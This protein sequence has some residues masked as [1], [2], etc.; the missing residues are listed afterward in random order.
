MMCTIPC[1][2]PTGSMVQVFISRVNLHPSCGLVELLVSE[3]GKT[4]CDRT[5]RERLTPLRKFDESEGKAGDFCLVLISGCWHRACVVSIQCQSCT[6]ILVD[7]GQPH[8]AARE[9]LAWGRDEDFNGASRGHVCILANVLSVGIECP[10]S[11]T[12]FLSSLPGKTFK[13]LVQHV[14]IPDTM[15]LIDIPLISKSMCKFGVA[16]KM[17]A[18]EFKCLVLKCW[19][20][21][22]GGVNGDR[23][24]ELVQKES[25]L[26]RDEDL[27]SPDLMYGIFET[28]KVTEVIDPQHIFCKLAIFSKAVKTFSEKIHRHYEE[29]ADVTELKPRHCG[30]P[31]AS[32]GEDGRWQRATLKQN[33]E[34][35]SCSAKVFFVDEGRTE[36][37]KI[38]N[39]RPLHET[40]LKMPVFTYR[41]S[42]DGVA[43]LGTGW[44]PDQTGYLKSLILNRTFVARLERH[45][46]TKDVYS[47]N[48]YGENAVCINHAYSE[49][50][51]LQQKGAP[52]PFSD[53]MSLQE[54][55]SLQQPTNVSES[56]GGAVLNQ[57]IQNEKSLSVTG[58]STTNAGSIGR[59]AKF[60]GCDGLPHN[61]GHL[62]TGYR[63]EF[64]Y[65]ND[66]LNE[67][68]EVDV[69]ISCVESSD[70]FWCQMSK[71][72][73]SLKRLMAELQDFYASPHP[74]P[75]VESVCV[76]RNPDNGKW[77]R[78]KIMTNNHNPAVEVRFID[79]GKTQRVPVQDIRPLD[80]AFLR[81]N[82]QAF[83]C[84]LAPKNDAS[85]V[86][87]SHFQKFV[88]TAVATKE[89]LKCIVK[90]KRCDEEGLSVN[91]VDITTLFGSASKL[92]DQE[93]SQAAA[94]VTSDKYTISEHGV[95]VG[96]SEKVLVTCVETV[97]HFYCQL[98]RNSK[99]L[100]RVRQT[101]KKLIRQPQESGGQP[102]ANSVCLARYTDNVWYRGQ[103]VE[104][105]PK[106]KVHLV[107][108]GD[109]L[110]VK[111]SDLRLLHAGACTSVPVLAV[112]L[113]LFGV[114][115]NTPPEVNHW[116]ANQAIGRNFDIS[117]VE[118]DRS[119]TLMV[120][121]F[122]ESLNI[123]E[124]IREAIAKVK[125]GTTPADK[126]VL[127]MMEEHQP[128]QAAQRDT[129][130]PGVVGVR[131]P[132]CMSAPEDPKILSPN[133]SIEVTAEGSLDHVLKN[134]GPVTANLISRD[135]ET[136]AIARTQNTY[137]NPDIQ[138]NQME[139]L[140]ASFVVGPNYFWCQI[141]SEEDLATLVQD[142][143]T[144][145][146][147]LLNPET[148]HLGSPCLALSNKTWYRAQVISQAEDKVHVIL[149]DYGHESDVPMQNLKVLPPSLLELPP[150]AFLCALKEF[151]ES[152]G[153]WNED[154]A[155]FFCSL[156]VDKPLKVSVCSIKEHLQKAVP[157]HAV[158][159]ECEGSV[160]NSQMHRHWNT[161]AKRILS[162]SSQNQTNGVISQENVVEESNSSFKKPL[163]DKNITAFASC[164]AEPKFFWC[165]L[166][167]AEILN[168]ISALA[169]AAGA[170][171]HEAVTPEALL[172][173][174]P[175]LALFPC[176]GQWY[177]A[178]VISR[179][180]DNV[181]VVFIDYG[182][183]SEVDVKDVR[184]LPKHL[185]DSPPA[186][187]LC[188]LNGFD[189]SSGL[190]GEKANDHFYNL[191][192]DRPLSLT[193][194]SVEDYPEMSL[195][196]YS[197][198]ISCEG[199]DVRAQMN[200]HWNPQAKEQK[201]ETRSEDAPA[202][203]P[204]VSKQ[205]TSNT[206]KEPTVS[207][208]KTEA[209]YASCIVEP[210]FF[211]CQP[212]NSDLTTI[213]TL[214]QEAGSNGQEV[215]NPETLVPGSPCLALF[216]SDN[217][218]YRA[219][220][221]S[222]VENKVQVVFI[223]YGNESEVELQDVRVL[224]KSLLDLPPLAF[225]CSLRGFDDTMGAWM[226][227]ATDVFYN[228]LVD[229]LLKVSIHKMEV[230]LE[231]AVPQYHVDLE[232][233]G[234]AVDKVMEKYWTK[235]RLVCSDLSSG[236][237]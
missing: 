85:F 49:M 71:N 32:R 38:E 194:C 160:V 139:G 50:M 45:D 100:E 89:Q 149:M 230:N 224:P 189:E 162:E 102:A 86:S 130:S 222:R 39:I 3:V 205:G 43:D 128:R 197:V 57:T 196:Q 171:A 179:A 177:R 103:V 125:D 146:E 77:Y 147:S 176:D 54:D 183:E 16:K 79:Y 20:L 99:H 8:V 136:S 215:T 68:S 180:D 166:A 42:M 143:G 173:G 96:G 193:V 104:T 226:D 18:E 120:E 206:Y 168:Q 172:P 188:S 167:N 27:F 123:N 69:D 84:S 158:E 203:S 64:P 202:A 65:S 14:L 232:C 216:T 132:H 81:L 207:G 26:G 93:C 25:K 62:S 97:N 229:K 235:N 92:F 5:R 117:V 112:P 223:D 138:Q 47:I 122:E 118:K 108:Y 67:G 109:T 213:S 133:A 191:L 161:V 7:Q 12:N 44:T 200:Q 111:R 209:A 150:L 159:I 9:D 51:A 114:P 214:S 220:V 126:Q 46:I 141:P 74:R 211:W 98:D 121:L 59:I 124:N 28:V 60:P 210:K 87:L 219:Q 29:S 82:A 170:A 113:G 164:I 174:T 151:D 221:I 34:D 116:F 80:P 48:L 76:A 190:W 101:I 88:D 78:A 187:F 201:P 142:A 10:E 165:Q 11:A 31:C 40:F 107:D 33:I 90:A 61:G 30:S 182:N 131:A 137:K 2:P 41:C 199:L 154:A 70:K 24:H 225:L 208:R 155:D 236:I 198:A 217:Q 204:A 52:V 148:L 181:H 195:L 63:S 175:C 228:L 233:E 186:A 135:Q 21:P 19:N 184:S 163:L 192:V 234:E 134:R 153:F 15:F 95:A 144:S 56:Q 129:A 178:Q 22:S 110:H 152:K 156:L 145:G 58:L 106:L 36:F 105:S 1:F 227:E 119:G 53:L 115:A 23:L 73:E 231:A 127:A 157:Q 169:Q 94:H 6:V 13:G 91:V 17:P 75:I 237:T 55:Q 212:E 83:Q 72:A 185:L 66:S 35:R 37:V 4:V 218:W 140:K